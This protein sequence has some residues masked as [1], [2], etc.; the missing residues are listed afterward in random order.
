MTEV[1]VDKSVKKRKFRLQK[2][3]VISMAI[4]IPI[5]VLWL[6]PLV[7]GFV[8]SFKTDADIDAHLLSF[9]PREI[10]FSRYAR[11]FAE[12]EQ[13]PVLMWLW[14]SRRIACGLRVRYAPF[15]GKRRALYL[16]AGNHDDSERDQPCAHVQHDGF[17]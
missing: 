2:G 5:T 15:Q 8:T 9:I 13:F 3:R 14:N 17:V 6:L 1:G 16:R 4:L 10:T 7:W 12:S 11:L